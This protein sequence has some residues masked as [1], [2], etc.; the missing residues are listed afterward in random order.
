MVQVYKKTTIQEI[1]NRTIQKVDA[2]T[3]SSINNII[4]NFVNYFKIKHL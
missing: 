4:S 1:E 2:T 3:Q